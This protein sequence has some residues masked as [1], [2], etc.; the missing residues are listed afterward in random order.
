MA[1]PAAQPA[2]YAT[3]TARLAQRPRAPLRLKARLAL[4]AARLEA[5]KAAGVRASLAL[6][7][8]ASPKP[9][10]GAAPRLVVA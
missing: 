1:Q 4:E 10:H 6:D 3:V 8:M 9:G 7:A 2:R 5:F